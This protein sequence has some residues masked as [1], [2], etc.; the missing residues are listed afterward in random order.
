L[1]VLGIAA[2]QVATQPPHGWGAW[3][4]LVSGAMAGGLI[5]T[6]LLA[7]FLGPGPAPSPTSPD[8]P[9]QPT[10]SDWTWLRR[11]LLPIAV[12]GIA[13]AVGT[14]ATFAVAE[15]RS[16]L[17]GCTTPVEVPVVASPETFETATAL[18]QAFELATARAG[19]G[20]P[21]ASFSVYSAEATDVQRALLDR[22]S[23]LDTGD[24]AP[25]DYLRDLG[26]QPQ[27]WMPDS[28]VDVD[29]LT[30]LINRTGV[31]SPLGT[32][33]I[34]SWSPL[35]LAVPKSRVLPE[36]AAGDWRDLLG[37]YTGSGF[38][39]V[40]PDS[41]TSIAG[42]LSLTATYSEQQ[43][44]SFSQLKAAQA[45]EALLTAGKQQA[46][47]PLGDTAALLRQ[48]QTS[49]CTAVPRI[50]LIL[51]EQFALRPKFADRQVRADLG[52]PGTA[53]SRGLRAVQPLDTPILNH[54][55]VPL[56]WDAAANSGAA[57][58]SADF[59][60]WLTTDAGKQ[61]I[62][63]TGLHAGDR[64]SPE[65]RSPA[66]VTPGLDPALVDRLDQAAAH[67]AQVARPVELLLAIDTSGSMATRFDLATAVLDS[68]AGR[69]ADSDRLGLLTFGGGV[70]GA[71][72]P[73]KP[74]PAGSTRT[75]GRAKPGETTRDAVR[76]TLARLDPAGGTPLLRGL[77]LGLR[78]L[79]ARPPAATGS[80]AS[81]PIRSLVVVTDGRDTVGGPNPA[82]ATDRARKAGVRVYVVATGSVD[83]TLP[84]LA[85]I[86]KRSGG[87]CLVARDSPEASADALAAAVWGV[88]DD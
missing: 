51:P 28:T 9:P 58:V 53:G 80:Q 21:S 69:L 87:D 1:A 42:Q 63:A 12:L 48:Y 39:V 47:Y 5:A 82:A 54:P 59:A 65:A 45:V 25:V 88:S 61:A 7:G 3:I 13:I 56:T 20:C 22:W 68:T 10:P 29:R 50:A 76:G 36:P 35:V 85:S 74:A 26:P 4:L 79:L 32:P 60:R 49:S 14:G 55:V 43:V 15:I 57:R 18:A 52:C 34:Y 70:D 40:R 83:C 11:L 84:V 77:D 24:P 81:T 41:N 62:E 2:P 8:D 27:I 73:V 6:G 44:W 16:A 67:H 30:V 46:G 64:R 75:G 72:L 38:D 71:R 33:T 86:T 17:R 37:V 66:R 19:H 23:V 78:T 31:A